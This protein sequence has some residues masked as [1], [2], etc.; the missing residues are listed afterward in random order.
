MGNLVLSC[1][2]V[3]PSE[4]GQSTDNAGDDFKYEPSVG[5]R[6]GRLGLVS[7][8]SEVECIHEPP[9]TITKVLSNALYAMAFHK[10]LAL[11]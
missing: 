8:M 2:P 9:T 1:V 6:T 10:H 11:T 5:G 4:E 3:I 7:L